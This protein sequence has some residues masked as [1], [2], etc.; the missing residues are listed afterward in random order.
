MLNKTVSYPCFCTANKKVIEIII[1]FCKIYNLPLVI[2][3][4]SAQVN[5]MG[6]YSNHTPKKF[7]E[8]I[9]K[10]CKKKKFKITN[11]IIGG[12]H[13]GPLP[14]KNKNTKKAIKNSKKSSIEKLY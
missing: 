12:D 2:E 13:I 10:I 11:L 7:K 14:W 1:V 9:L 5:Q 6:G 4:T 3:S 8:L